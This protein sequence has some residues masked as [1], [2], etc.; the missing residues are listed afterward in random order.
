MAAL[1]EKKRNLL[2]QA[3]RRLTANLGHPAIFGKEPVELQ[4]WPNT[5]QY[6]KRTASYLVGIISVLPGLHAARMKRALEH[7]DGAHLIQLLGAAGWR[8][9]DGQRSEIELR[10]DT[11]LAITAPWPEELQVGDAPLDTLSGVKPSNERGRFIVGPDT[12]GDVVTLQ[13]GVAKMST[14]AH[15]IHHALIAGTTGSGKTWFMRS[16]V[17]Q[18]CQQ[19]G[20]QIVII[21]GKGG[22]GV[23]FLRNVPGQVGPTVI[24]NIDQSK[25]ALLWAVNECKRRYR[26]MEADRVDRYDGS[27]VYV[28]VSEFTLLT[29]DK[30]GAADPACIYMLAWLAMKGRAAGVHL[31]MD[32]Q[33]PKASSFGDTSTRKQFDFTQC[34]RVA[35]QYDTAAALPPGVDLRPYLTLTKPGDGYTFIEARGRRTLAAYVRPH[36]LAEIIDSAAPRFDEWSEFDADDLEGFE[37]PRG[38]GQPEKSFDAGEIAAALSVLKRSGDKKRM[39][40]SEVGS[41]SNER[42]VLLFALAR[43]LET[44]LDARDYCAFVRP[45]I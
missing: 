20:A 19:P 5:G 3:S 30:I 16:L 43:E 28:F 35:D 9:P 4:E 39:L 41:I 12:A 8:I 34:F 23:G 33:Y 11:S 45:G 37:S 26:T 18:L 31:I 38:P 29:A 14:D 17:W 15:I 25:A 13:F 24:D 36:K 44:E 7:E 10:N 32:T 21:D 22:D 42:A 27:P 2:E 40:R 6:T 1:F